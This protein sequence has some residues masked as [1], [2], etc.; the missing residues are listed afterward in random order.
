MTCLYIV[1]ICLDCLSLFVYL[2]RYVLPFF[3]WAYLRLFACIRMLSLV[4]PRLKGTY[5]KERILFA[6][7]LCRGSCWEGNDFMQA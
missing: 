5:I 7:L 1:C 2:F 6:L 3:V 4:V